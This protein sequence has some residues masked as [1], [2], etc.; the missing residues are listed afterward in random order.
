MRDSSL[1]VMVGT[2]ILT[3]LLD[4]GEPTCYALKVDDKEILLDEEDLR[5]LRAAIDALNDARRCPV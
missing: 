5:C 2:V 1:A 3:E 4:G